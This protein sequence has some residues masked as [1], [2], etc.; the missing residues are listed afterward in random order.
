MAES[1]LR[2]GRVLERQSAAACLA[3]MARSK[4]GPGADG[5][6]VPIVFFFPFVLNSGGEV[7]FGKE[8][9]DIS[10]FVFNQYGQ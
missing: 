6:S 2:H 10:I 1:R 9:W 8:Y 7:C 4:A 3:S 5:S